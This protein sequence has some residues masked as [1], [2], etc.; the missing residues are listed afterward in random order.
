MFNDT[1]GTISEASLDV[2]FSEAASVE[3][4]TADGHVFLVKA[5]GE[6]S[7]NSYSKI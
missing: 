2:G 4:K 6:Y 5:A 7:D 3:A 1:L